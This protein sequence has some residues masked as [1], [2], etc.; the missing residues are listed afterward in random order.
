MTYAG[1]Y[2]YDGLWASLVTHLQ[3]DGLSF[4]HASMLA[5]RD[6]AEIERSGR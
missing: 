1:D 4:V 6:L 5:D 3:A 2:D